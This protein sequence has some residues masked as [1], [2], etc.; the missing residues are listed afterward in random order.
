MLVASACFTVNMHAQVSDNF[1][2]G[3]FTLNPFWQGDHA[4]FVVSGGKLKLQAP[5]NA[6]SAF[7]STT[8]TAIHEA[9]W[10]FALQMDFNPSSAN[11]AR[12]YLVADTPELLGPVNGY[13]VKVGNTSREVSLYRQSGTTE[14]ELIDGLDDRVNLPSVNI[15]IRV[16]RSANGLWELFSDVGRTGNFLK[17]GEISD[18]THMSSGWMGFQCV[19]TATRSDKFWFD[20]VEVTGSEVP[21]TSPPSI[22]SVEA[23]S[24]TLIQATFSEPLDPDIAVNPVNVRI[25]GLGSPHAATLHHDQI[26]IDWTLQQPLTNGVTYRAEFSGFADLAG[27]TMT[28]TERAIRF[29]Q[30]GIAKRRS[31]L[32]TEIFAD[33]TP[34]LGLPAAEYVE[35]FNSSEEPFDLTG[36]KLSDGASTG[37]LPSSILLPAEYKVIT[38]GSAGALFGQAMSVIPITNFPSLNNDGDAVVIR[39]SEGNT[40]DSVRY[41]VEWYKDEDKAQ[42][43][44]SLEMIDLNNPCSDADNWVASEDDRG[45]TPG[46]QNSVYA[47][48]PDRTPPLIV[49]AFP[50]DEGRISIAFN[51]WL[52]ASSTLE[53]KISIVPSVAAESIS[54]ADET[55]RRLEIGLQSSLQT[56]TFYQLTVSEVRDC[57]GNVMTPTSLTFGLPEPSDSL[58]V[59]INELLF[60]PRPGGA[61]FVELLNRSDKFIDLTNWAI[62]NSDIRALVQP[63]VLHP[64]QIIAFTPDPGVIQSHYP[65]SAAGT[66]LMVKMP[67]LPDDEGEVLIADSSGRLMDRLRYHKSWH[68]E[69]L[70]N[71]EGVSLERIDTDV[72]TQQPDNWISA[73]ALAGYATPGQA[74]SQ[75]RPTLSSRHEIFVTPEVFVPGR[76]TFG[77]VQIAYHFDSP[78]NVA[79]VKIL[80][81][82]G[83]VIRHLTNNEWLGTEGF[84]RWDGEKDDGTMAAA[85]YYVVWFECFNAQGT[86]STARRRIVI[87]GH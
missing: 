52:H 14:T 5:A 82:S 58:D 63:L 18:L 35:V 59:I 15:Q 8:S 45:G 51:E 83:M 1:S 70:R 61:D 44:W 29:F 60:N 4:R 54:F 43:G 86:V 3:D 47:N 16:T 71:N 62:G 87:A 65:Q 2:D 38:T 66:V 31:V 80:S 42:G 73:S 72:S 84:L 36:W 55:R 33:P 21:D 27:N 67:N 69:F 85:G 46:Q 20:D 48:K 32:I 39:D 75:L 17:E 79:S 26:T 81:H 53:A 78:G 13:F 40:I 10:S 57:N 49:A 68:S 74:N 24:P 23:V 30:P 25:D 28:I 12:I 37:T 6:G 7:L 22:V 76:E 9:S 41:S 56:R 11:L 34:Q 77:F 64:Q 19:Y 50:L